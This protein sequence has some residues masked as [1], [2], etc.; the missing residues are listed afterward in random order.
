MLLA[1][2]MLRNTVAGADGV[3]AFV[4]VDISGQWVN[5]LD[6]L[7]SNTNGKPEI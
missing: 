1:S 6:A 3:I 4:I 7:P 5:T 2:E